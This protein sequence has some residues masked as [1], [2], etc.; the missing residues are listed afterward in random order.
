[1]LINAGVNINQHKLWEEP[2]GNEK[3]EDKINKSRE[4]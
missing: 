3:K 2:F 1:M 4:R